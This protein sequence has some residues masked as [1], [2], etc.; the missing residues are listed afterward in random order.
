MNMRFDFHVEDLRQQQRLKE[1]ARLQKMAELREIALAA[2]RAQRKSVLL[3]LREK[4]SGIRLRITP[5]VEPAPHLVE[6]CL[7]TPEQSV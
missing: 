5:P 2:R 4:L 6:P 3:M 1:A 7:P